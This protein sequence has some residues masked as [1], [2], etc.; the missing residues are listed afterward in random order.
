MTISGLPLA[1]IF[2]F[3]AFGHE[4]IVSMFGVVIAHGH[5]GNDRALFAPLKVL[6]DDG[7]ITGDAELGAVSESVRH[8][9]QNHVLHETTHIQ[10]VSGLSVAGK[11]ENQFDRSVEELEISTAMVAPGLFVVPV[12][13]MMRE[14]GRSVVAF[15]L[16]QDLVRLCGTIGVVGLGRNARLQ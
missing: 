9:T 6:V 5:A 14:S 10:E 4:L 7:A 11:V 15:A 1:E 2:E 3:D 13:F 16:L 12:D 8:Q